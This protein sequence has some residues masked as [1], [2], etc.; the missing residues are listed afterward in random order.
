MNATNHSHQE[1]PRVACVTG[2]TGMIGNLIV[3]NLLADGYTVRVLTRREYLNPRVQVFRGDLSDLFKLDAFISGA[4]MV[5]H[6]AAELR[7]TSK[8]QAVNVLG[9]KNIVKLVGQHRVRYLCHLSSAGV[10]GKTS[11]PWVDESTPCQPQDNYEISKLEA[12]EYASSRIAGRST[13]ILRPTNVVDQNH[14]GELSLPANGSL[15][16]RVNAFIKGGECAHIV[17]AEDVARAALY[18]ADRPPLQNPGLFF[19][20][21]DDD[22]MNTVAHL[23]SLYTAMKA[24]QENEQITPLPHLPLIIPH[25]LRRIA[26]GTGNCGNVRYSSKRLISEGFRFSLGVRDAVAKIVRERGMH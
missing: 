24:G 6:C 10:V 18:F 9:T 22:P 8:M 16:S 5:F 13:V 21:L 1:G 14:L 12:E 7:D 20:S 25:I 19:V 15:R 26:R 2:A 4:D 11:E 3:R 23:W 17:H